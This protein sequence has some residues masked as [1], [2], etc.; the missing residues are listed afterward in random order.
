MGTRQIENGVKFLIRVC[1][2]LRLIDL[3]KFVMCT[4][5]FRDCVPFCRYI[6]CHVYPGNQGIHDKLNQ[7]Q[8]YFIMT[9]MNN[10]ENIHDKDINKT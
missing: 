6:K 3:V 1:C 4:L 9:E 5:I 10:K 2:C 8:I 7:I